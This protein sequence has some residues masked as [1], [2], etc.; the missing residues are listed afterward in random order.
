MRE[1]IRNFQRIALAR[2]RVAERV[3]IDDA[4]R[5]RLMYIKDIHIM[6]FCVNCGTTLTGPFCANCGTKSVVVIQKQ[7]PGIT[8]DDNTLKVVDKDGDVITL[9]VEDGSIKIGYY[10]DT[11]LKWDA[12]PYIIVKYPSSSNKGSMD[13]EISYIDGV[14]QKNTW[15]IRYKFLSTITTFLK[16]LV[17]AGKLVTSVTR[18]SGTAYQA[19]AQDMTEGSTKLRGGTNQ[20]MGILNPYLLHKTDST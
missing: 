1:F 18:G 2:G 3:P 11:Y 8:D 20:Y 5:F 10:E 7:E 14:P 19:T 13:I 4:L 15:T 9:K 12:T 16:T 17:D 6:V